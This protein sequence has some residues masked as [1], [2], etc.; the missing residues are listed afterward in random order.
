MH[1]QFPRKLDKKLV[2][3]EQSYQWIKFVHKGETESTTVQL[4]TMQSV[5][6]I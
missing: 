5:Q 1:G 2:D 4:N 3:N 6:I